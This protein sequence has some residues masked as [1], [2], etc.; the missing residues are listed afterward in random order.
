MPT[1]ALTEGV[2]A[3]CA[4][5]P[6]LLTPLDWLNEELAE[7]LTKAPMARLKLFEADVARVH[8]LAVVLAHLKAKPTEELITGVLTRPFNDVFGAVI[9]D[10]PQGLGRALH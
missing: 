6:Y 7:P 1:A 10:R 5:R 4:T 9:H 8:L 3:S 2:D